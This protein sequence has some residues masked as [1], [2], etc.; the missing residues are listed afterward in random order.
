MLWG[1]AVALAAGLGLAPARA[2]GSDSVTLSATRTLTLLSPSTFHDD[3]P[4]DGWVLGGGHGDDG[5]WLGVLRA[6]VS[7]FVANSGSCA[8][9][10][11]VSLQLVSPSR[12]AYSTGLVYASRNGDSLFPTPIA[13]DANGTADI[14]VT[15]ADGHGPLPQFLIVLGG[16]GQGPAS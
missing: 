2:C 8:P 11:Y 12:S 4:A 7:K 6:Q 5:H 14:S 13:L 3:D 1:A 15:H 16:S 10:R 9:T